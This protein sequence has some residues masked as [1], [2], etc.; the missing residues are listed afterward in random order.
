M[1]KRKNGTK[2][3]EI[4]DWSQLDKNTLILVKKAVKEILD[5]KGKHTRVYNSSIRRYL[6]QANSFNNKNLIK[7]HEY[8]K[9][10]TEDIDSYRI[11][12]IKWDIQ[13]LSSREEMITRYKIQLVAGFGGIC[14]DNVKNLINNVLENA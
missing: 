2:T 4:K 12:K 14:D 10:V 11:R 9:K 3:E 13:E 1:P 7:T 8:I 5:L 6:G